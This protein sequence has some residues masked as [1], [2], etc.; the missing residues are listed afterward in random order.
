MISLALLLI[1]LNSVAIIE[2][3][4]KGTVFNSGNFNTLWDR[5]ENHIIS[6]TIISYQYGYGLLMSRVPTLRFIFCFLYINAL[7]K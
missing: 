3:N 2:Q 1:T 6:K 7:I 5:K 4:H